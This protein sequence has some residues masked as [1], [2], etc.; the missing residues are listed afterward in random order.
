MTIAMPSEIGLAGTLDTLMARR[1]QGFSLEQSFYVSPDIFRTD[2]DAIYRKSWLFVG[3]ISRIPKPGDFFL[4]EMAGDSIIVIR[5]DDGGVNA[6]LNVC[7]HRGARICL[8]DQGHC[9]KLVCP[10]HSWAF[11]KAGN[12]INCR[13]MPADFD[14]SEFPLRR[15]HTRVVE[16]LIY[17]SLADAP[18]EFE[19]I[20]RDIVPFLGPH[21]LAN[22]KIAHH[23]RYLVRANWK[24]VIE[25]FQECYHCAPAHPEYCRVMSW[26]TTLTT[27][28]KSQ[29]ADTFSAYLE[30]WKK[31]PNRHY[32]KFVDATLDT[33]HECSR[34]IIGPGKVSQSKDGKAVSRLL[35]EFV[36]YDGATTTVRVLTSWVAS[37]NDYAM[38]IRCTP[39]EPQLTEMDCNWIVHG[40]ARE[41]VDYN[42]DDVTW[43]WKTTYGQDVALAENNQRGVN[44]P[45][46]VPGP[47]SL[48]ESG[49]SLFVD[50][51]L[52]QLRNYLDLSAH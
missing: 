33:I 30:E 37:A 39:L 1:R 26:V 4:Y 40:D 25:N 35:G 38:L 23:H 9:G 22:T 21:H 14:K 32:P 51:Y 12:L 2:I 50:W 17:I 46:Y 42:V 3:H 36:E 44:T 29:V 48:T 20:A 49:T 16:G 8:T 19:P 43:L 18:M 47:Y 11:D 27:G 7:R 15:A 5:D 28:Q 10:Y 41:G 34:T 45:S 13:D 6:L 31:K 24:L 52:K